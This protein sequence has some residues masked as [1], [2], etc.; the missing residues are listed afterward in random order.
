MH[1]KFNINRERNNHV[2]YMEYE[3]DYC[4]FH[5][6]SPI[7]LYFVDGG[8]MEMLAAGKAQTLHAG[9]MCISLPYD[10]H[11]YKTPEKSSSSVFIIPSELSAAFLTELG[12]KRLSTPYI[13][14]KSVVLQIKDYISLANSASNRTTLLGYISLILGL[15]LSSSELCD[16]TALRKDDLISRILLYIEEKHTDGLTPGEIA[17]Y[18]GYSQSYISRYFK[19]EIG[20]TLSEYISMARLRYAAALIANGTPIGTA[21]LDSGFGSA[22]AFYRAFHKEFGCTP[23]EYICGNNIST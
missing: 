16:N 18:F 2:Y 19:A 14:D 23:K 5:F 3:N 11:A 13:T 10:A 4:L 9:E 1:P 7:E 6:H 17:R 12:E 22:R 15:V 20:I 8:E 21:A